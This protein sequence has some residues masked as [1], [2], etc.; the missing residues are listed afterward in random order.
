MYYSKNEKE[1]IFNEIKENGFSLLHNI[2]SEETLNKIKNSLLRMLNYIKPDNKIMDLQ[3]KYYQ[4]KDYSPI[5]KGHFY[6]MCA[7]E[8][9]TRQALHDP[10]IIDLVKGFFNTETVFSGRPAI[11][12][13]DSENEQYLEPH[14]ETGQYSKDNMLLWAPLYDAK[15]DQ[16]GLCIYQDSHKHG[17]QRHDAKNKLGSTQIEPKIINKF[18]KKLLEVDAGGALLIHSAVIH[19]SVETKKKRFARFI[20]TERFCPLQKIP[21]L[22]KEDVPLKIPY[23][24]KYF[25]GG[26]IDYESI[27]D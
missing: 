5:L 18:K 12:I 20:I 8:F 17:Y 6:D 11:H 21:Y 7:Y 15:G 19:E 13:H 10:R 16:G 9:E 25:A 3:E 22:R 27:E 26:D 23:A 14:Q 24:G 2:Y 4:I 1:K